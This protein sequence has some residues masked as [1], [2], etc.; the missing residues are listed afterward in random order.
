MQLKAALNRVQKHQ[1]FVYEQVHRAQRLSWT[2]S[3][4][5]YRR[6]TPAGPRSARSEIRRR[7][8]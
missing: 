2:D 1:S 8:C 5:G 7:V 3:Y 6:F 4:P